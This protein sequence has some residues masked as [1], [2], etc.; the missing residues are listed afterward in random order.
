MKKENRM[1]LKNVKYLAGVLG[2]LIF[3]AGFWMWGSNAFKPGMSEERLTVTAFSIGK[4]D[5]LLLQ[6]GDTAVLVDT[7]E[8]GDGTF[9]LEELKKRGIGQ[10]DLLMVT[11][12]DKDHVGS[13]SFLMEN[14]DVDVV[15]MPD[16][17]GDRPE[18]T[19]FLESLAGH[20]DVRRLTE[21]LQ[22]NI[23]ALEW[24]VY[25]AEDPAE[26]QDTEGEYD[27]DMS[28][29]AS[30]AYGERKFLLTGDI[31]KTRI[32]QMLDTDTDWKHDWIKMPHHGRYQKALKELMDAVQPSMA[33]ICC[34]EKNPAEEKTLEML[35]ER[36]IQVWDTS[37]YS[38]VTVCDGMNISVNCQ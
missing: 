11:H 19:A 36:K 37:E 6:E 29:V 24:I 17:E 2:L 34:S 30:V 35:E 27:N 23:G 7:G 28:L 4:A 12:F 32:R 22:F 25:P 26:I 10:L 5:A 14:L 9:L 38:V 15:M 18:Y 8:E 20:P 1:D 3:L 21:P 16:Y 33:V 13:A 31:E